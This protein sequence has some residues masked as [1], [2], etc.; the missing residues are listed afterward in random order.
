[1]EVKTLEE[2]YIIKVTTRITEENL[3][4]FK[5]HINQPEFMEGYNKGVRTI[6]KIITEENLAIQGHIK[7]IQEE[8][9]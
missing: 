9:L 3:K 6:L 2:E 1:M 7:R 5:E 4:V 8:L